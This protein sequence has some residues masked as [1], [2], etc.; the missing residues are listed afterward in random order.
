[1]LNR[2]HVWFPGGIVIGAILGWLIMDVLGLSWQV[3]VGALFIPL[4]IYG[5]LFFGQKFLLPNEF[6]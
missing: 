4:V 3:M 5:V 6:S 2:F 1:M